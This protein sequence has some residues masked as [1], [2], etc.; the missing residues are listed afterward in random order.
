[1][2]KKQ[3]SNLIKNSDCSIK[4]ING[5]LTWLRSKNVYITALPYRCCDNSSKVSFYYSIVDM[6]DFDK[7]E[8]IL[9]DEYSLGTSN[10]EFSSF[11]QAIE[12]GLI[13]YL[14]VAERMKYEY[15]GY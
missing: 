8:D 6:N 11:D 14:T 9:F 1:M 4:S 10:E 3:I 13:V 7:N 12:K 2:I 15:L 5:I